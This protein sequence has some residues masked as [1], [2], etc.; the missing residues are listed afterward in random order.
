MAKLWST[1]YLLGWDQRGVL[2]WNHMIN[3]CTFKYLIILSKRGIISRNIKK[4]RNL[5]LCVDCLFEKSHKSPQR[6]K[7]KHSGESIRNYLETIPG[8]PTSI[9][10]IFS[11]QLRLIPQVTGSLTCAILWGATFFT[12]TLNTDVPASL[13][14]YK[15]EETLHVKEAYE[16]LVAINRSRVCV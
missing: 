10:Q 16:R 12:T 9:G 6:T 15:L 4:V 5:L 14:V 13:G 11:A 2:V 7:G 3:H 8:Y 1:K